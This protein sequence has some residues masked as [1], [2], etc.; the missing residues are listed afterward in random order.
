MMQLLYT[1]DLAIKALVYMAINDG[2]T[3]TFNEL[4]KVFDVV[5]TS[6]KRPFRVLVDKGIVH[7]A[8]G[9]NGGLRLQWDPAKIHLGELIALLESDMYI[10]PLLKP[11]ENG[12]PSHPDSVY[13]FTA[14]HSTLAF[15]SKWDG[16][17]IAGLVAD[18]HT[19]SAFGIH[20]RKTR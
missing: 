3:V 7:S 6:F 4:G 10:V 17:T 18:P 12:A 15:L 1:T 8:Q 14:V 9:R 13:R 19:R 16:L 20:N 11:N 5:P 2:S